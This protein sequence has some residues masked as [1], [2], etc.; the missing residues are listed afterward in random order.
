MLMVDTGYARSRQEAGMS[1][2]HMDTEVVRQ[3]TAVRRDSDSFKLVRPVG[4]EKDQD[5][6]E[7][8]FTDAARQPAERKEPRWEEC[9]P[10][11][12]LG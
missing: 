7:F 1:T 6:R 10:E 11:V 4:S 8:W 5:T 9:P 2:I 3:A 12:Y